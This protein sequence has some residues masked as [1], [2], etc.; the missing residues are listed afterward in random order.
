MSTIAKNTAD[1][2]LVTQIFDCGSITAACR[3][4][5]LERT[6][7]SR[8]LKALEERIGVSLFDRSGRTI[9]LTDSGCAFLRYCYLVRELVQEAEHYVTGGA[10][11]VPGT[12]NIVADFEEADLFLSPVVSEYSA[13]QPGFEVVISL[14]PEPLKKLPDEAD[15]AIQMDS[16]NQPDAR[17]HELAMLPR[18][19]WASPY[20]VANNKLDDNPR[21]VEELP[22][23]GISGASN[24]ADSW[25]L[26]RENR[27]ITLAVLPRFRLPTLVAC[28]RACISS[29]GLAILPDYLCQ[30]AH[31]EGELERVFHDW[32]PTAVRLTATHHHSGNTLTRI[33][34]FVTFCKSRDFNP[35]VERS[36][37]QSLP[38]PH[39]QYT[40]QRRARKYT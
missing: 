6:T 15:L 24:G 12:L 4:A 38:G 36:V 14:L 7:L 10:P 33:R 26:S 31:L 25:T 30:R 37:P 18:S 29:L 32:H 5:G 16:K 3:T 19:V 28:R 9:Q 20:F 40:D 27:T 8:R 39:H 21:I 1:M 17:T 13:T 11:R 23:I 2:I 22:C 35:T 34:S